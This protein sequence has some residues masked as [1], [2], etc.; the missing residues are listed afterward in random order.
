MTTKRC[1]HGMQTFYNK[2]GTVQHYSCLI[3]KQKSEGT[4]NLYESTISM[5]GEQQQD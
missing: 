5:S 3:C 2:D 4:F 1:E